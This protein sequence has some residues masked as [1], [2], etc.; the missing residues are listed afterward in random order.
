MRNFSTESGKLHKE[1]A[2]VRKTFGKK[3]CLHPEA[4][5][6]CRGKIVNAHTIQRSG[7]LTSIAEDGH[8]L[9]PDPYTDP[10]EFKKIGVRRAS[11]FSG[12]CKFHD[13][14]LFA[15]I[16]KHDLRLNRRHAFLI[17]FR[18]VSHELYLKRRTVELHIPEGA[19][20]PDFMLSYQAGARIAIRD[21][22]RLHND[23]GNA[24]RNRRFRKTKFFAIE[25]D[26]DPQVLCSGTPNVEFDFHGNHLQI[27]TRRK[28]LEYI[29]F[30]IL[31]FNGNRSVAVFAWYEKSHVNASFIRSLS[32]LSKK[33]IPDAVVRFAFQHL[34]NLFLAPTWWDRTPD[35][36]KELLLKRYDSTFWR[37]GKT[38]I[39][40]RPDGV[41][42]VDWKVTD[43]KTNLKL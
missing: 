34:E 19:P 4:P 25:F 20:F 9:T 24:L 36:V 38:L 28:P 27:L 11:T 2:G 18:V 7:G 5:H 39:D 41:K 35:T 8:V 6:N 26:A 29:T 15:P 31:P 16:E 14:T 13:D 21:L 10:T 33:Q 30:S 17:A 37:D 3:E 43:F 22:D 40:L 12:F 23:M 42:L 32:S 1:T